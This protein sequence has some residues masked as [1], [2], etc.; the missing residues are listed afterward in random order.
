MVIGEPDALGMKT[1]EARSPDRRAPVTGQVSVTLVV[2]EDEDNVR[3]SSKARSLLPG[4]DA[5]SDTAG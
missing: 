1:V 4:P 3:F 2:R 5:A